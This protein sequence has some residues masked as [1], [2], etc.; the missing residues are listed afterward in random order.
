[1]PPGLLLQGQAALLT[2]AAI[3]PIP[4]TPDAEKPVNL[5]NVFDLLGDMHTPDTARQHHFPRR[6][7]RSVS[8]SP[9]ERPA[10]GEHGPVAALQSLI[11]ILPGEGEA[12]QKLRVKWSA[13]RETGTAEHQS[14]PTA[15]RRQSAKAAERGRSQPPRALRPQ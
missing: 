11:P 7:H 14:H 6:E 3:Q 5:S 10:A 15:R 9:P 13:I 2:R 8:R 4:L 1:M 12:M